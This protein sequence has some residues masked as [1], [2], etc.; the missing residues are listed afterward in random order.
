MTNYKTESI[1]DDRIRSD[2]MPEMYI[3]IPEKVQQASKVIIICSGGGFNKVNLDHEGHQF[4]EWLNSLNIV[5]CVLNYSLPDGTD[6]HITEKDLR[7]AVR[8]VKNNA[9]KWG[10]DKPSIGA[11]GF[12]IG[13]HAVSLVATKVESDSKLD[14]SMLF[15]SVTSMQD[16]ITHISSRNK[17]LGSDPSKEEIYNFTALNHISEKT[18]PCFVMACSDDSIVSPLNSVLY[19]ERLLKHNVPATLYIFPKGGHAWGMN[20]DFQYH[21]EILSLLE[22]WIKEI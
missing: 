17:L 22:K 2:T 4:A 9:G 15:Y 7:Q 1:F 19:Y 18:P 21:A 16:K 6:K 5:G 14:F 13:G 3:H 11:A 20:K 10:L 8:F 12:S